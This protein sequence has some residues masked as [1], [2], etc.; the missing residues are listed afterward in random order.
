MGDPEYRKLQWD[1]RWA[2]HM[3]PI[4]ALMRAA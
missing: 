1:G 2:A 3:A 4:N